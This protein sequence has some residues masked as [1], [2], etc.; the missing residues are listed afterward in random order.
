MSHIWMDGRVHSPEGVGKLRLPSGRLCAVAVTNFTPS[1]S[2][3][4]L[5][6]SR[7]AHTCAMYTCAC[8]CVCYVIMLR[9]CSKI[10]GTNAVQSN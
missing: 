7:L 5:I 10:N 4:L 8:V 6:L 3:S 1:F 9:F 2:S